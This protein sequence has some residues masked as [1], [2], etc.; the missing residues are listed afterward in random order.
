[1]D[2]S[3]SRLANF[4][5]LSYIKFL[6]MQCVKMHLLAWLSHQHDRRLNKPVAC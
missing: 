6:S 2:N 4:Y 1:M 3:L 5:P